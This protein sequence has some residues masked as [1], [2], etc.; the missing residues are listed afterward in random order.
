MTLDETK[1]AANPDAVAKIFVTNGFSTALS[2]V[3]DR[4]TR[5]DGLLPAKTQSLTA[6]QSLLQQQ[7]D[8][9]NK[10]ADDLR[11]RLERQ[12]TALEEAMSKLKSQATYIGS[13]SS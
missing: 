4:Y 13:L 5:A 3:V 7:I 8:R 12:F 10:N 2:G 11:A 9:I 6:R 1:L